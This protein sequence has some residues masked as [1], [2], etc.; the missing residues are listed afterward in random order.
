M[1]AND[2]TPEERDL[3][4][5]ALRNPAIRGPL[6]FLGPLDLQSTLH[7]ARAL[8]REH[9]ELQAELRLTRMLQAVLSRP[10]ALDYLRARRAEP[11]ARW[12]LLAAYRLGLMGGAR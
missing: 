12:L 4:A 3:L 11:A 5:R 1:D 7:M 9:Q 2:L 10:G 8:E 6:E